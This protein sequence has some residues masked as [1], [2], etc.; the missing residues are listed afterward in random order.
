MKKNILFNLFLALLFVCVLLASCN[1]QGGE[2][3]TDPFTESITVSP[4]TTDEVTEDI[5]EPE[6]TETET[7]EAETTEAETTETETVT[8]PPETTA[9]PK[10][11]EGLVFVHELD[12][13]PIAFLVEVGKTLP[14]SALEVIFLPSGSRN[15]KVDF[16]G[17]E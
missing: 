4:V 17:W 9:E 13:K 1:P 6:T 14:S 3:T 12:G 11:D 5:T 8:V 2:V 16:K 10:P 15:V 7:T